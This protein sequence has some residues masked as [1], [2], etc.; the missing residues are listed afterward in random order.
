MKTVY[1]SRTTG[2]YV[3]NSY[4]KRYPSRVKSLRVRAGNQ[5]N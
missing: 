4:A 1:I 5:F 2:R 3:S